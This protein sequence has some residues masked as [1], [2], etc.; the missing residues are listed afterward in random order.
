[1][2]FLL[3]ALGAVALF[4]VATGGHPGD[5]IKAI[6]DRTQAIKDDHGNLYF[7]L[8]DTMPNT[9]VT[10]GVP[11]WVYEETP[12]GTQSYSQLAVS[13]IP[14]TGQIDFGL[15]GADGAEIY[16]PRSHFALGSPKAS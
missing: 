7:P 13:A 5:A 12:D 10:M 11:A 8:A 2:P 9:V 6:A 15:T 14:P 4:F 1:M 3:I 16:L